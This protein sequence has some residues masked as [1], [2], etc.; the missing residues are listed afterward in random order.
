[1]EPE[2]RTRPSEG[3]RQ[4]SKHEENTGARTVQRALFIGTRSSLNLGG[5]P[6]AKKIVLSKLQGNQRHRKPGETEQLPLMSTYLAE[7]RHT[8]SRL[9]HGERLRAF[10]ENASF[11]PRNLFQGFAENLMQTRQWCMRLGETWRT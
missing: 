10:L 9:L 2:G 7:H 6:T 3:A 1:M 11:L 5:A 8:A 4:A